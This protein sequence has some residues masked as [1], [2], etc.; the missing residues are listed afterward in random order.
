MLKIHI[1]HLTRL[2]IYMQ[3]RSVLLINIRN[4]HIYIYIHASYLACI[5]IKKIE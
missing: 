3:L 1:L 2:I 4:D 5:T